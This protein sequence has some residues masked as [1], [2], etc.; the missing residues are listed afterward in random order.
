MAIWE[1]LKIAPQKRSKDRVNIVFSDFTLGASLF[2]VLRYGLTVGQKLSLKE[3]TQFWQ[4]EIKERI[5]AKALRLLSCRPRTLA[6]MKQRLFEYL[7][8]SEPTLKKAPAFLQLKTGKIIEKIIKD[9]KDESLLSDLN[10]ARWWVEQRFVFRPRS[11]LELKGEL[12][13]RGVSRNLIDRALAESDYDEEQMAK[14]LLEKKLKTL[15]DIK[16]K[17]KKLISY[18]AR[19]GFSYKLIK[20]LID[21]RGIL[22]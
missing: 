13:R 12:A 8:K 18:L 4:D 21:E 6:E 15:A 2:L 14:S 11:V 16:E 22:A 7:K 19:K 10:F 20:S 3:L 1:I 17:R 9:L 5:R